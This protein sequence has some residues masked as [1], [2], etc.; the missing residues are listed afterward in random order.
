MIKKLR[1]DLLELD[2][3]DEVVEDHYLE[4]SRVE[5][6]ST[7]GRSIFD[8][9]DEFEIQEVFEEF[10]EYDD[11]GRVQI[12]RYNLESGCTTREKLIN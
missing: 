7:L 9:P 12:V 2:E 11:S 6:L 1:Y 8:D 5:A 10:I 3:I 4:A